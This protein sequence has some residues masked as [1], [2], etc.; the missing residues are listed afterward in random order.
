MYSQ[1]NFLS[2]LFRPHLWGGGGGNYIIK[3]VFFVQSI[4]ADRYIHRRE[5]W[6][7]SLKS[8]SSV[9]I[10]IKNIFLI[11]VFFRGVSEDWI[12][13]WTTGFLFTFSVIFLQIKLF[14]IKIYFKLKFLAKMNQFRVP[15]RLKASKMTSCGLIGSF[16]I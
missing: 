2:F 12:F 3:R 1:F 11:F 15:N 8:W 4:L 13:V 7:V 10:K 16:N 6:V 5:M 14:S 9:K